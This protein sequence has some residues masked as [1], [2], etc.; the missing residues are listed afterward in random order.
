MGDLR[1]LDWFPKRFSEG[2]MDSAGAKR[3]LGVPKVSAT[4]VLVRETAQNSWDA[5][6]DNSRIDFTID[7]R[8]LRGDALD[9]LTDVVFADGAAAIGVDQLLSNEAVRAI[10]ISDRGT[11]GL[12]GPP[13]NDRPFAPGESMNFA[14]F[15]FNLGA[16]RD[17]ELGGG[18]YGFGKTIAYVVSAISTVVLWTRCR[19]ERGLEH[20]LIVSAMGE[21][22]DRDD[23]R[24]TGRHWWGERIED[25]IFPIVGD[26]AAALGEALFSSRFAGE[27][28]GTSIL[29]IDPV[30]EADTD[31]EILAD[32]RDAIRWN[33]WPKLVDAP[34]RDRMAIQLKYL[35]TPHP[36]EDPA[37][38]PELAPY[39]DCLRA[40]RA[41][42]A[43]QES[44]GTSWP[45]TVID[46]QTERSYGLLGHLALT[47][48]PSPSDAPDSLTHHV[49][50]M[51]TD[52]ELVVKYDEHRRLADSD[53]M[54]AGVFK[55]VRERDDAFADAEP[56]AHDDWVVK[57]IQNKERRRQ[58]N[59]ALREIRS[60]VSEFVSPGI[61][62]TAPKDDAPSTAGLA[63]RLAGLLT[64]LQGHGASPTVTVSRPPSQRRKRPKVSA[65]AGTPVASD[66]PGWNRI[67]FAVVV[68]GGAPEGELVALT[69]GVGYDGGSGTTDVSEWVRP[70]GWSETGSTGP[71]SLRG[72][73]ASEYEVEFRED[74]ALDVDVRVVGAQ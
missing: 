1:P 65:T 73:R 2:D 21:A 68:E 5:R 38:D 33:L 24:Y 42:Q 56:P 22:F 50:L 59:L 13:R 61:G 51:R 29:I 70:I 64:G 7:L 41:R 49:A 60:H 8:S 20:R 57:G 32:L 55:P 18:T 62:V 23:Y 4:E 9:V 14:N 46:I 28:T 40:V 17:V 30:L 66:R 36:I 6:G 37:G 48:W 67:V 15:V 19:T 12:D 58:V 26:R 34:D 16:P 52:A 11:V 10:E 74:V 54:W 63:N 35:G 31:H 39:V 43:G 27:E 71:I 44:P 69:A 47:R 3:L 45:V 53:F 25:R 72:G